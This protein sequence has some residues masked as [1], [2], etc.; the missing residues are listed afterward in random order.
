MVASQITG[1][2]TLKELRVLC[3]AHG[4]GVIKLEVD[5]PS[6]SQILIPAQENKDFN[7]YI[8]LVKQFYQT[9]E[10]KVLIGII[11]ILK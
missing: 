3:A 1:S 2:D 11:L 8:K 7:N 10:I 9:G 4:I 6:E 5:N